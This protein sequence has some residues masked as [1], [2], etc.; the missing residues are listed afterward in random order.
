MVSTPRKAAVAVGAIHF[1][2]VVVFAVWIYVANAHEGESPMYWLFLVLADLPVSLLLGPLTAPFYGRPG[3]SWL[4][5]LIGDWGNYLL[6]FL[7]F[8]VVGTAWWSCVG[9]VIGYIYTTIRSRR[10]RTTRTI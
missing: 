9:W 5:G 3:V 10:A 1:G 7:F 6:P 2:I 8:A 4:P